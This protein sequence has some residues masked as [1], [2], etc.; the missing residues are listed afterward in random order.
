M[1]KSITADSTS[2]SSTHTEEEQTK[3]ALE[4]ISSWSP[5]F[6]RA[7]IDL[8]YDLVNELISRKLVRTYRIPGAHWSYGGRLLG[9]TDEGFTVICGPFVTASRA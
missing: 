7:A 3:A 8:G 1:N 2:M 4:Y 5:I 9:L 6:K